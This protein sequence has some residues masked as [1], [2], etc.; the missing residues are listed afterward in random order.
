DCNAPADACVSPG[1]NTHTYSSNGAYTV[2]LN[3]ITNTCP[4]GALCFAAPMTETVASLQIVVGPSGCTKEYAPVCGAKPV[5]CITAPC[6]PVPTTYSNRCMMGADNAAYLYDG[7]CKDTSADP[8]NDMQC[9]SWNDGCN[10]CGRSTPGGSA[11][12]TLKYCSPE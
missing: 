5:V 12:C 11:F 3:K 10:S 6:N 2:K 7:A 9:K 1:Q 8:A 4:D